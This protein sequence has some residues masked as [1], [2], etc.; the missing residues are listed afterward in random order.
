MADRRS[1]SLWSFVLPPLAALVLASCT[2]VWSKEG[3][4]QA[5]LER[6]Y[7]R[8]KREFFTTRCMKAA[9]WTHYR[10]WL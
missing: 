7:G 4:I 9:G 2:T 8:C 3:A 1:K 10:L 5:D 6:D